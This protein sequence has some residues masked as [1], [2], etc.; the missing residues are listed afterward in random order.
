MISKEM[1]RYSLKNLKHS[2]T[3]SFL[4]ILS[5]FIGI[6]T[7][8][9]FVS[10]GMGLYTYIGE[11]TGESSAN[12]VII[13]AKG[14]SAP[15]LDDSFQLTKDDLN[16]VEH[17][18]DVKTAQ[19]IYFKVAE[20]S[21]KD[22]KRFVFLTAYNPENKLVEE[23]FGI[24]IIKGRGLRSGD[25]SKVVLGY[26]YLLDDKIF[27][28]AL[29]INDVID[30]QDQEARV[31]GFFEGVGN[32]Q[33]DANIYVTE[34][35]FE[36][37]YP[38]NNSY[39]WIVAEVDDVERAVEDIEK[40]LRKERD[41]E[42]GKEDFFVQS[43]DELIESYT[44]ALDI[45]IGFVILIALI[46]VIVSAINTSNTMITSV[47]ERFREIGI[48]KS[49]GARNADILKLFLFESAFLG[50]VGGLIGIGLGFVLSFIGGEILAML[51]WGFL[52]PVFSP[53]LFIGCLIFA[54]LTGAISG[55]L[56]AYRA[57][58]IDPVDA[59]RYE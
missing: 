46:S 58:R 19:G 44:S 55:L 50:F 4:T 37:L 2:K 42:E 8:F 33:D 26:N 51:G 39:A 20:V 17:S 36:E 18:R 53:Y 27:S 24:D 32:P 5:I 59:L 12:K 54:T 30:I 14:M 56:P 21:R 22:E 45:V 52:S 47:L 31:I 57:S 29:K 49:V 10:F 6:A 3:R 34:S 25:K 28:R 15:G 1:I 41:Q 48:I 13:Q 16:A 38:G 7:I 43:F 35:Y 40:N 11:L 9:I 23:V